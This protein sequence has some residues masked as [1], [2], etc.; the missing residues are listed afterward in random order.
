VSHVRRGAIGVLLAVCCAC[1]AV[2]PVASASAS[3]FGI[4]AIVETYVPKI[5]EAE[6]R[7]VSALGEY[8]RTGALTKVD[9]ALNQN[10]TLLQEMRSKIAAQS[11]ASKRVKLAK[12]KLEKGLRRIISA[13][14][15]LENALA[16]KHTN[17][18][19]A[20]ADTK[21]AI[22]AIKRGDKEISE[23]DVLLK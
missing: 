6:G 22:A 12:R 9:E 15:G 10:I 14:R 19:A 13:E 11:A 17:P 5:V 20:K 23:A 2:G 18:E 8:E 1:C 16:V 7:V 21:K 4:I 3:R